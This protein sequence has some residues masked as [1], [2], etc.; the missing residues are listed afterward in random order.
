VNKDQR[1]EQLL[2]E[3]G[4][5]DVRFPEGLII[6]SRNRLLNTNTMAPETTTISWIKLF[7]TYI[8]KILVLLFLGFLA[9][10]HAW[11]LLMK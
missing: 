11:L 4:Q 10:K 3:V 9:Y 8:I 2:R 1:L 5:E 6:R 7:I